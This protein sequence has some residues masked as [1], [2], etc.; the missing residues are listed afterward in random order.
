MILAQTKRTQ[1]IIFS[2]VNGFTLVEL[3]V[4]ISIFMIIVLIALGALI[5]SSDIAKRSKA[6]RSAMDNVNFSMESMTRTLRMGSDYTCVTS[7]SSVVLPVSTN[8]D[9]SLSTSGGGAI[10]FTRADDSIQRN[11]AY[12]LVERADR[13][14]SFVLQ[15]CDPNCSNLT[16]DDVNIERLSFYVNGSDTTDNIQPSVY[17]LMKGSVIIKGVPT[18]FAIQ[19]ITSQ[20]SGE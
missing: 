14:N 20:R 13:S 6:L 4:A 9:C 12:R 1:K 16:S 19:T 5:S 7:G 10:V 11:F 8:Y 3:M 15:R 17:I 2:K 18:S